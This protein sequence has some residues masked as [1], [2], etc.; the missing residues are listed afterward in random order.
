[1]KRPWYLDSGFWWIGVVVILVIA[2]SR[3]EA[4]TVSISPPIEDTTIDEND[5][6]AVLGG[7]PFL[8]GRPGTQL[9][10][11]SVN[12]FSVI[13]PHSRVND[14]AWW[15]FFE[16]WE[17]SGVYLSTGLM[18]ENWDEATT[19]AESDGGFRDSVFL[20]PELP[21][22][23]YD[24]FSGWYVLAATEWVREWRTGPNRGILAIPSG[25]EL[26]IRSNDHWG[27]GK[28][29]LIIDYD[30]PGDVDGDGLFTQFDIVIVLQAGKY[31]TGQPAT[32]GE[33]DWNQDG[34]FN[35]LDL[36][37]AL[38]ETGYSP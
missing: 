3:C 1:M 31:N 12:P 15:L 22:W 21:V 18:T 9:L 16:D 36:V 5:P 29:E 23:S 33:G 11:K 6:N 27:A 38:A 32:W 10:L 37:T 24:N 35:Q 30:P 4:I 13:P 19:W 14:A 25:G 17:D 7:D 26:T 8:Y 2:A 28:P 34:V 20:S